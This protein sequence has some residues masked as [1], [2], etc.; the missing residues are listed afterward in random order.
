[1]VMPPSHEYTFPV[2]NAA[3][4]DARNTIMGAISSGFARRPI[5]WR[6][7]TM[8]RASTGSGYA[9]MRCASDGVSTVPGAIALQRTPFC[10]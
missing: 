9:L 4:S 5:G 6:A 10:T 7:T 8:R 3:S 1:M 2:T